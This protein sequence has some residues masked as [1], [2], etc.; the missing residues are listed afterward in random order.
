MQFRKVVQYYLMLYQPSNVTI[1]I[2]SSQMPLQDIISDNDP[3][4]LVISTTCIICT[5]CNKV[6]QNILKPNFRIFAITVSCSFFGEFMEASRSSTTNRLQSTH[7]EV[8]RGVAQ[9][10]SLIHL[11]NRS[12]RFKVDVLIKAR[13]VLH[14]RLSLLRFF[15]LIS[16]LCPRWVD[17]LVGC[18]SVQASERGEQPIPAQLSQLLALISPRDH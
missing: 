9:I 17:L 14:G 10:D 7:A 12:P 13:L 5:G 3:Y 6:T 2:F 15:H 11:S 8:R 4:K 1:P 16:F 18:D